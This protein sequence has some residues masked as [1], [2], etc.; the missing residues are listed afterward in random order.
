MDLQEGSIGRN[1][2]SVAIDKTLARGFD[3][4]IEIVAEA[5]NPAPFH[6]AHTHG[7]A[8]IISGV[9]RDALDVRFVDQR[10]RVLPRQLLT[11]KEATALRSIAQV[12]GPQIIGLCPSLPDLSLS[13]Y[14]SNL[15]G[16]IQRNEFRGFL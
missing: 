3:A 5:T 15:A 14:H 1:I 2:R 10:S 8:Q 7:I 16:P 6:P 9:G 4:A 13:S 12:R 11:L